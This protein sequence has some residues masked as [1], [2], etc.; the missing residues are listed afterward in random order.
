MNEN[1]IFCPNCMK[2]SAFHIVNKKEQYRVKGEN[3]EID[4]S[5]AIC[6]SCNEEVFH[7]DYDEQNLERAYNAYR[8]KHKLLFPH[9]IKSIREKY[10]L[11][12]RKFAKILGWGQITIHRYETGAVPDIAHS[13]MLRLLADPLNMKCLIE[14]KSEILPQKDYESLTLTIKNL[15]DGTKIQRF[16]EYILQIYNDEEPSI[17]TGFKRFDFDKFAYMIVFFATL[18]K[19]LYKTKLWKLMWYSDMLYFKRNSVSISGAYY[20]HLPHGPV[21]D[22]HDTLLSTMSRED[23]IQ[24][25]PDGFGDVILRRV[26][27]DNK[28]FSDDEI[29]VLKEVNSYFENYSATKIRE[30]SHQEKGYANTTDGQLISFSYASDLSIN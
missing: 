12:Q 23:I 30:Y 27:F 4:A 24:I 15:I 16:R 1:K 21:P 5:V 3:I 25:A 6:D 13:D 8:A 2:Y 22:Q 26:E 11:S 18:N 14:Q 10:G 20:A 17:N 7:P 19:T 9:E 29:L 28:L